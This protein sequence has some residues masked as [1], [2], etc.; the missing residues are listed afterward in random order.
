M[1][2]NLGLVM[3]SALGALLVSMSVVRFVLPKLSKVVKG[4]YLDATLQDSRAESTE[5]LGI[6]AGDQGIALTTLRPSGSS[7]I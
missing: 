2:K 6:C 5:A 7:S 1:I 4:P 3:G